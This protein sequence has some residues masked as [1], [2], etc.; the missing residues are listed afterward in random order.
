MTTGQHQLIEK[1]VP[2]SIKKLIP[3]QSARRIA[4]G[5]KNTENHVWLN[6]NELE[7][8]CQY[9]DEKE[10][11]NS[12]YNRYPDYLPTDLAFAYWDYCKQAQPV[13]A[14]SAEIMAVRGADEAIDLLVRTFCKPGND[15]ILVCPPTYG[16][17]EFCADSMGVKTAVVPLTAEFQLNL[18]DIKKQLAETS[19]VF[20]C[21]PNNP[22]GNVLAQQDLVDLLECTKDEALVVVDEAYIEFAPQSTVLHL[23]SQY[24]HLVVIRTLSKAFGLAAIRIGFLIGDQSVMSYVSRLVAPYPIADPSAEIALKALS[25]TGRQQMAQQT[26]ELIEIRDWFMG[27]VSQLPMVE[28]VFPSSTNFVLIRFK[29]SENFYQYLLNHGVVARSP[30]QEATVKGCVRISIGSAESMTKTLDVLK[31]Y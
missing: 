6:A 8:C 5:M 25:P 13:M 1:L 27:E 24:P 2:D 14:D 12:H 20:L 26:S 28:K 10:G 23:M 19:I 15:Q 22:T 29:G 11:G 7:V 17:Y 16:M 31:Q 18:I 3:Y 4:R 21:S 30:A 9:G